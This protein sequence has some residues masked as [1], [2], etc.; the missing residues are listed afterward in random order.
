[1]QG[2]LTE[3]VRAAMADGQERAETEDGA[4]AARRGRIE[5]QMESINPL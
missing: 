1:M 5:G 2:M 3:A 4:P